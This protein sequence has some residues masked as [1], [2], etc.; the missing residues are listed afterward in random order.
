MTYVFRSPVSLGVGIPLSVSIGTTAECF[1]HGKFLSSVP[2]RTGVLALLQ[3]SSKG[4][5]LAQIE[6]TENFGALMW[7]E[8]I[9]EGYD[10]LGDAFRRFVEGEKR[11]DAFVVD[12]KRYDAFTL[13]KPTH[14]SH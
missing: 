2:S 6:L 1:S 14:A 10:S 3:V 13:G 12:G 7:R 11:H 4:I 5:L 9:F 8:D